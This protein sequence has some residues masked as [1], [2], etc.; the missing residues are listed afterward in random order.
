MYT[1]RMLAL[2]LIALVVLASTPVGAQ[3]DEVKVLKA[4]FYAPAVSD[5]D[6]ADL[7]RVDIEV[8]IPGIGDVNVEA[9]GKVDNTTYMSMKMAVYTAALYAGLDWRRI[10]ASIRLETPQNVAGPSGSLGVAVVTYQLLTRGHA[11]EGLTITGAISPDGTASRV[12]SVDLKCRAA[13]EAG[14]TFIYPLVN[15]TEKLRTT[16][17]GIPVPSIV[18]A[19]ATILGLGPFQVATIL[20]IPPEFNAAMRDA[21]REI[22]SKA[23]RVAEDAPDNV[24]MA[25]EERINASRQVMDVSPYASA[26]LAFTALVTAYNGYYQARLANGSN[27]Y[28]SILSEVGEVKG[29]LE[30]LRRELDSHSLN[31]SIY[32][33]EFLSTAYTRLANAEASLEEARS[34]AEDRSPL[35]ENAISSL[36]VSRARVE[37]IR[38]WIDTAERMKAVGPTVTAGELR[39]ATVRYGGYTRQ[40]VEYANSILEYMIKYYN[41]PEDVLGVRIKIINRLVSE[42]RGYEGQG[43]YVAALGFYRE[44]LSMTLSSIFGFFLARSSSD[45]INGYYNDL[46]TLHS[47]IQS[48]LASIGLSSGLAL[49]Y[50]EYAS[51]L[52]GEEP[53]TAISLLEEAVASSIA[54]YML[55]LKE[56]GRVVTVAGEGGGLLLR[57]PALTIILSTA[58]YMLALVVVS[59]YIASAYRRITGT[60]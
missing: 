52:V 29:I 10:D 37:T 4:W 59:Q 21:A 41:A 56:P 58:S 19:T 11:A 30:D 46:E 3:Q 32:Y 15:M 43:N 7:I 13:E 22:A 9:G 26:S 42:A 25:V 53:S 33:I 12:G 6:G 16:C 5:E 60:T 47:M 48:R 45:I 54:W 14:S 40:A 51:I 55:T 44:A 34:L 8:R 27:I 38:A 18:N 17:N 31:G 39:E 24:R 49:A 28:E 36:A 1:R 23:L 35:I 20:E 57:D 2:L 50:E